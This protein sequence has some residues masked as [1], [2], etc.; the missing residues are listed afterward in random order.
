VALRGRV[1]DGRQQPIAA[2]TVRLEGSGGSPMMQGPRGG[3]PKP[4]QTS[5]DGH[6]EVRIAASDR[7]AG[8]WS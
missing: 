8:R 7:L 4:V 3:W 2:A 1:V 6:F 5:A